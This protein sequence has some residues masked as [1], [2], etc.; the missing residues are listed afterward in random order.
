[1]KSSVSIQCV[2]WVWTMTA[3]SCSLSSQ[4]WQLIFK[5]C[6]KPGITWRLPENSPTSRATEPHSATCSSLHLW[7]ISTRWLYPTTL[8]HFLSNRL[9]A[10][11][12]SQ[13]MR[14]FCHASYSS[15]CQCFVSLSQMWF[16]P[17]DALMRGPLSIHLRLLFWLRLKL[18]CH[19]YYAIRH[20]HTPAVVCH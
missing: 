7:F 14:L 11:A 5:C 17:H 18:F 13:W 10:I 20:S 1:M 3:L 12:L 9:Q 6:A 8:R 19:H 2:D 4:Q 16:E 15:L